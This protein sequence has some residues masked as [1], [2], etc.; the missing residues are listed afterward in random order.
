MWLDKELTTKQ[1]LM[2]AIGFM[3]FTQIS[4]CGNSESSKSA[5]YEPRYTSTAG[6]DATAFMY[7]EA[8]IPTRCMNGVW[9]Y[10]GEFRYNTYFA[11]VF[12]KKGTVA[13]CDGTQKQYVPEPEVGI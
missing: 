4:G 12:T 1:L 9:Y 2:I 11:P 5:I 3:S 13:L 8:Y 10:A 7:T 6:D